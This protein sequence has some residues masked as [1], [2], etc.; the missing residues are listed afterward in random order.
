MN[1]PAPFLEALLAGRRDECRR[2]VD[3]LIANGVTPRTLYVEL[4]HEALYEVGRRWEHGQVTVLIEHRATAI[5]EE[6]I[7]H[8]FPS[9]ARRPRLGRRALVSC[10][11][12]ELHQLGGRIVADTLEGA[13]WDVDFLGANGTLD[14]LRSRLLGG[15][16]ELVALSVSLTTNLPKLTALVH[17]VRQTNATVP[18]VVGGR[19]LLDGGAAFVEGLQVPGVHWLASLDSLE[20]YLKDAT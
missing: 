18:I 17:M 7:G 12:D 6:L 15:R 11:A 5:V 19:A 8:V 2:I 9:V 16:F 1:D 13:G 20:R 3:S 14:E 10:A 4:F